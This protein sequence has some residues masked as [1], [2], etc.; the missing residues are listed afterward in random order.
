MVDT[1]VLVWNW[2]QANNN[3][4]TDWIV[5]ML[6]H[7]SYLINSYQSTHW[8]RYVPMNWVIIHWGDGLLSVKTLPEAMLTYF[9]LDT[10]ITMTLLS[11][12]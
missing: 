11:V 7:H 4:N 1:D 3:H 8:D 9:Q 12:R 6:S 10:Y 5:T 2:Y